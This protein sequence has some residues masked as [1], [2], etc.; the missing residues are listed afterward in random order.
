[1]VLAT[2]ALIHHKRILWAERKYHGR[3]KYKALKIIRYH[4]SF[5]YVVQE[6]R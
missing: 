5:L 6:W 3:A 1:M 4:D 2:N